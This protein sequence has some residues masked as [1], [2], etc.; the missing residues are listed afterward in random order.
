MSDDKSDSHDSTVSL[1]HTAHNISLLDETVH[2]EPQQI[3]DKPNNPPSEQEHKLKANNI[4]CRQKAAGPS[5]PVHEEYIDGLE[6]GTFEDD[7]RACLMDLNVDNIRKVNTISYKFVSSNFHVIIV[8]D[9][10]KETVYGVR[11]FPLGV[12]VKSFRIYLQDGANKS[13]Q[14]ELMLPLKRQCI[15]QL[16]PERIQNLTPINN[17]HSR[18]HSFSVPRWRAHANNDNKEFNTMPNPHNSRVNGREQPQTSH[19]DYTQPSQTVHPDYR[20]PQMFSRQHHGQL[21]QFSRPEYRHSS[22]TPSHST[23]YNYSSPVNMH[24]QQTVNNNYHRPEVTNVLLYPVTE[25]NNDRTAQML[26]YQINNNHI[27]PGKPH[28]YRQPAANKKKIAIKLL[29]GLTNFNQQE[30][31]HSNNKTNSTQRCQPVGFKNKQHRY[32]NMCVINCCSIRNKLSYVLDHVKNHKSDIV[33]ITKSWLSSE[34]CNNRAVSHECADHDYKL[35]PV[36]SPNRRG[37]GVALLIKNGLHVIKQTH[38]TRK[39]LEHIELLVTTIT[40][41]LR[42]VVIYRPHNR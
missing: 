17:R 34:E 31:P 15:S 32:M 16:E 35:F 36:P 12:I 22:V 40:I 19:L 5:K 25:Y 18:T 42:I 4:P 29:K 11:K 26:P 20:Q 28:R 23:N 1:I 24:T 33:S 3:N 37:G 39:T 8:A 6:Y 10:I 38:S 7:V 21:Q 9:T 41:H 30:Q 13:P 14:T 27:Y 2:A